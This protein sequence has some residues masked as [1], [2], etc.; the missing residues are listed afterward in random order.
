MQ[1]PPCLFNT[2]I[3]QFAKLVV[4]ISYVNRYI[5]FKFLKCYL[6]LVY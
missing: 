5:N 3:L 1:T 4:L 2:Y 6:I